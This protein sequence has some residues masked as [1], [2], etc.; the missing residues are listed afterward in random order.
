MTSHIIEV[1]GQIKIQCSELLIFGLS[2]LNFLGEVVFIFWVSLSSF[3]GKV[4]FFFFG[5][6]VCLV[7][8][9]QC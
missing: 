1:S 6:V 2:H 5:E 3:I 4:V 8:T 9:K 7:V